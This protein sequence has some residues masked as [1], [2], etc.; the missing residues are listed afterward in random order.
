MLSRRSTF[1]SFL[2]TASLLAAWL[3]AP[4]AAAAQGGAQK[5]PFPMSE[6]SIKAGRAIYAKNCRN[7]HGLNGEGDGPAPPPGVIPANLAAGKFKHGGTDPEIFKT[8][9]DGVAPKFDM[10][11]WGG[12]LSDNDIWN[13]IN[14]IHDLQAKKAAKDA[15]K[16]GAAP[17]K[18]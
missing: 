12:E 10:K 17:K 3:G 5:N 16:K 7:C 1:A 4:A 6:D 11:A 18:K 14:Y 2:T 9:K 13:T 8:I 15:L